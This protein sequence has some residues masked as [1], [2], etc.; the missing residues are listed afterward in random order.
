MRQG[1]PQRVR[2]FRYLKAGCCHITGA[3]EPRP[4][5]LPASI[6]VTIRHDG[7]RNWHKKPAHTTLS[8]APFS[9]LHPYAPPP[10]VSVMV[11]E[12]PLF[13]GSLSWKKLQATVVNDI[14]PEV[15]FFSLI[16]TSKNVHPVSSSADVSH[17]GLCR[18]K[19]D[20]HRFECLKPAVDRIGYRVGF[21]HLFPNFIRLRKVSFLPRPRGRT[22]NTSPGSPRA[23]D[24]GP[25]FS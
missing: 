5:R 2:E 3:V 19:V 16:A 10:S 20:F 18:W 17:S 7:F 9:L 22:L 24:S 21:G 23:A 8:N 13:Q 14:W 6:E 4:G 15:L 25:V 12:N 1:Y 11:A